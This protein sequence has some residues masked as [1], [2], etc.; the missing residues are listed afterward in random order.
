MRLCI[1]QDDQPSV[2]TPEMTT[3]TSA[4]AL[5]DPLVWQQVSA[6]YQTHSPHADPVH[7]KTPMLKYKPYVEDQILYV[8]VEKDTRAWLFAVFLRA[9]CKTHK[10]VMVERRRNSF[11]LFMCGLRGI[12]PVAEVTV[13]E[14][15][16]AYVIQCKKMRGAWTVCDT[17]ETQERAEEEVFRAFNIKPSLHETI[18][19]PFII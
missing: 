5:Y 2:W 3:V 1:V 15:P 16:Q 10:M 11:E 9:V 18:V 13:H 7:M 4:A 6:M 14:D 12:A 17:V 8:K 19:E